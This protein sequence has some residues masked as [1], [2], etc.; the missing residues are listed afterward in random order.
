MQP[1]FCFA[2]SLR[3]LCLLASRELRDC[4]IIPPFS[5]ARAS[6]VTIAPQSLTACE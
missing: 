1:W 4:P 3:A 2:A 5:N 6:L